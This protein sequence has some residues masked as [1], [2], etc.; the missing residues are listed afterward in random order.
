MGGLEFLGLGPG[1]FHHVVGNPDLDI[2][3]EAFSAGSHAK[4]GQ[5]ERQGQNECEE[6][7]H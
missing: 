7:L 1:Q 2:T 5:H 3:G 6:F 4:Q